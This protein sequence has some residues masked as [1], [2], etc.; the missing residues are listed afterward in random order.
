MS[1]RLVSRVLFGVLFVAG[2]L[3]HFRDPAFYLPMMPDALPAHGALVQLSGV[4]EVVAG[5]LLFVPKGAIHA[6]GARFVVLHLV[7]FLYVHWFMALH[8]ERYPDIPVAALYIRIV[9]QLVFIAWSGWLSMPQ[10]PSV[11]TPAQAS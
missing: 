4:T 1:L 7:V 5:A 2:G 11:V 10:R 8:P 9:V 3:N 6:W